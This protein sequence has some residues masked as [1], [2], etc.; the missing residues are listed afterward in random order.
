MPDITNPQAVQ[1]C[2]QELRRATSQIVS[3]FR[4][5]RQLRADYA[6]KGIGPLV[7]GTTDLQ[8]SLVADGSATDGRTPITGYDVDL[9]MGKVGV[10]MDWVDSGAQAAMLAAIEKPSVETTPLF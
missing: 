5:L 7:A 8:N 4:T 2:N 10:L 9:C 3:A 1:F 6:F